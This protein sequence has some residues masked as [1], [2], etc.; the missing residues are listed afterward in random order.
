MTR[1]S[2]SVPSLVPALFGLLCL[3]EQPQFYRFCLLPASY[4]LQFVYT[5][6]DVWGCLGQAQVFSTV[7]LSMCLHPPTY[8][9]CP[10]AGCAASSPEWCCNVWKD[11]WFAHFILDSIG[12]TNCCCSDWTAL[13]YIHISLMI[14]FANKVFGMSLCLQ[15]KA[16]FIHGWNHWHACFPYRDIAPTC[17]RY[18]FQLLS[19][20]YCSYVLL[21]TT[22]QL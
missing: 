17:P 18:R 11:N 14:H 10:P 4:I 8:V 20:M 12:Y 15:C 2:G 1:C 16:W 5:G 21:Y 9:L 13:Y 19:I 6:A 7:Q 3:G 22:W